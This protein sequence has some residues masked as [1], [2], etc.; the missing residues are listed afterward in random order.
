MERVKI[1]ATH[2]EKIFAILFS[3][4][5]LISCI[6]REKDKVPKKNN[7]QLDWI[8]YKWPSK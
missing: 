2:W 8:L 4:E 6:F 3:E 1:Q 7:R 5:E